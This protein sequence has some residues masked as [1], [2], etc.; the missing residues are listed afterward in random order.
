MECRG[1][2]GSY[3]RALAVLRRPDLPGGVGQ[4]HRARLPASGPAPRRG[5]RTAE[6][7]AAR[8]VT[9]LGAARSP[10]DH[11]LP[12]LG[13]RRSDEAPGG[14]PRGI[15]DERRRD[16]AAAA[17]LAPANDSRPACAHV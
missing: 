14:P 8:P 7:A 6:L 17:L 11:W 3:R 5:R 4:D 16:R 2:A 13:R 12:P 9:R 1:S 10:A 15:L